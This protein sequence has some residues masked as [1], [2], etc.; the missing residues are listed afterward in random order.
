[1]D[2]DTRQ[3]EGKKSFSHLRY[4]PLDPEV[5]FYLYSRV[6]GM[7]ADSMV[8]L[9]HSGWRHEQMSWKRTCYL[10][11]GLN[12]TPTFRIK[13][14]DALRL[15][16]ETCVNSFA[17]FPVG[18]LRHA[19]MCN[20]EGLVM[21]HGTVLRMGEDD[22]LTYFLAPYVAYKFYTG[23]YDANGEWVGD[24]FLLQLGGPRSLEVLAVAT[25]GC[26]HDVGFFRHRRAASK[27]EA[28][29]SPGWGWRARSPTK[30]TVR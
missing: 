17:D 27:A 11:A 15:F 12:P 24:W 4:A 8:P 18:S 20:D 26:L 1:M 23:G 6:A 22:F 14:P 29:A 16:S 2:D 28:F 13:G 21:Q 9:E 25:G 30:S 7:G 10:H 5:D 3:V 19:I